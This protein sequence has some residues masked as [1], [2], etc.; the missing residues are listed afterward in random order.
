MEPIAA[1]SPQ[2]SAR[3]QPT[4]MPTSLLEAGFCATARNAR[5]SG[6]NRTNAYSNTT[7]A[8]VTPT[9]P[10]SCAEKRLLASPDL[11][12]KGLGNVLIVYVKIQPARLLKIT[13]NPMNT[14]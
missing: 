1:A 9:D 12:G 4:R 14:T 10:I 5:P 13:S 11:S 3:I 7:T 8:S 2:P 6:V